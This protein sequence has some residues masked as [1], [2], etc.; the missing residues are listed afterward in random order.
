MDRPKN[1]SVDRFL[2]QGDRRSNC[3][4]TTLDETVTHC[5]TC[6]VYSAP[7]L[8]QLPRITQRLNRRSVLVISINYWLD[9]HSFETPMTGDTECQ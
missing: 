2:Y 7:E 6:A 9:W 4:V 5:P 1:K 3:R 8:Y